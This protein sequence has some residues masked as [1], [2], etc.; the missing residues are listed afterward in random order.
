[1]RLPDTPLIAVDPT[2]VGL[3]AQVDATNQLRLAQ[4]L[5]GSHLH[6]ADVASDVRRP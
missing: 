4:Q 6:Q 1:M 2:A 3:A 5:A